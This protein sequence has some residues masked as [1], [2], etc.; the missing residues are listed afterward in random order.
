[1]YKYSEDIAFGGITE[2][3][4]LDEKELEEWTIINVTRDGH[5]ND[6]YF[7]PL[8]DG[9]LDGGNTQLQFADAVNTVRTEMENEN[10]VFVYCGMGQSRSVS[11]IATAIAAEEGTTF[12]EVLNKLLEARKTSIAPAESLQEKSKIYL[13]H[14]Q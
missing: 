8:N 11:V 4:N 13:R 9:E 14:T 7:I 1:M 6:D 5:A 12:N 2:R 10:K 3:K